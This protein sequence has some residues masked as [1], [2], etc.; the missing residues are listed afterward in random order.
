[1]CR[2]ICARQEN[3]YRSDVDKVTDIAWHCCDN[4]IVPHRQTL[5]VNLEDLGVMWT[6]RLLTKAEQ[7]RHGTIV[8]RSPVSLGVLW[9]S[10][11]AA[12]LA[13]TTDYDSLKQQAKTMRTSKITEVRQLISKLQKAQHAGEDALDLYVFAEHDA[14]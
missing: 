12:Y 4:Q 8:V 14:V 2:R 3:V 5:W 13:P 11:C 1:M 9:K 6:H 7:H 10:P